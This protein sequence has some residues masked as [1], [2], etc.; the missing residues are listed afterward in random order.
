MRHDC[1]RLDCLGIPRL[2]HIS[3]NRTTEWPEADLYICL[4]GVGQACMNVLPPYFIRV[5]GCC[6]KCENDPDRQHGIWR[7]SARLDFVLKW[8]RHGRQKYQQ[9][10]LRSAAHVPVPS[11]PTSQAH[12]TPYI[13]VFLS[14][15]DTWTHVYV[16]HGMMNT[17]G[18]D[19]LDCAKW[20]LQ[21]TRC[22]TAGASDFCFF[23]LV[24]F[25]LVSTL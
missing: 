25:C 2:S 12:S 15:H 8:R 13:K 14:K 23:C 4:Y 1:D 16:Q 18:H 11:E 3:H 6:W 19:R 20:S 22:R 24:P 17:P 10:L 21:D 7:S 5:C 9:V